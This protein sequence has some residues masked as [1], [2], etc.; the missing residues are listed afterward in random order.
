MNCLGE[1]ETQLN[2]ALRTSR[3]TELWTFANLNLAIV[4]LRYVECNAALR[5]SRETELWTFANLNLAIV[6]LRYRIQ[7]DPNPGILLNQDPEPYFAESGSSPD[8]GQGGILR[9][10]RKYTVVKNIGYKVKNLFFKYCISS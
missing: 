7:T 5:T 10:R 8:P 1:A 6:Y 9:R 4:Y 3:E 2:A